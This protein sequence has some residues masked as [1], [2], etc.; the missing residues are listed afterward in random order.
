MWARKDR[1]RLIQSGDAPIPTRGYLRVPENPTLEPIELQ[2]EPADAGPFGPEESEVPIAQASVP[3][4]AEDQPDR[5]TILLVEDDPGVRQLWAKVLARSGFHVL[6]AAS[7]AEALEI[8]VDRKEP[9]DLLLTDVIMPGMSGLDLARRLQDDRPSLPVVFMSGYAEDVIVHQGIV[10]AGV[11][12]I[13]KPF[14][15]GTL[16]ERV[17]GAIGRP[18]IPRPGG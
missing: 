18:V 11:D 15:A 6:A 12:L 1:P 17:S 10:D 9:L 4:P 14:T 7:G 13:E 2:P 3:A 5:G 16:L 8:A